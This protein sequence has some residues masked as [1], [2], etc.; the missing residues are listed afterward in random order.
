VFKANI[1]WTAAGIEV[2]KDRLHTWVA[3]AGVDKSRKVVVRLEDPLSGAAPTRALMGLWAKYP[4]DTVGIDPR[5]PSATLVEPLT[6]EGLPLKVADAHGVACAHGGFRD[7]IEDGRIVLAGNKALDRAAQKA[8]ERKLA[9]AA[10]IDRYA[11]PDVSPL[12]AAELAAWALGDPDD[13]DGLSPEQVTVHW[14]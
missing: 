3:L 9:G 5:S 14:L 2:A 7:L 1:R 13:A 10:A 11:G 6:N 4:I 8:T 12:N